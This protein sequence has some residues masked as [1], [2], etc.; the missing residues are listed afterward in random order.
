VRVHVLEQQ[1]VIPR[2]V[3]ELWEFFADAHNLEALTPSYLRFAVRSPRPI[4]LHRGTLVEYRLTY[5]GV[6]LRWRTTIERWDPPRGFTDRQVSGP[7]ALWH[8][9]HTF[10]PHPR[11]TLMRDRVRY[12]VPFGVLGG[13]AGLAFVHRDVRGIF[14]FR[15]REI[16]RRFGAEP[17]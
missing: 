10:Q 7:Y 9:A 8:H 13:L 11:G 15:R 3:D 4:V 2:P 5:R 12:R 16:E 17:A 1:Q 6:P 14:A